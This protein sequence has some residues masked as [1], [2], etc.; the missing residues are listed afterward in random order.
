[1]GC[2]YS[3]IPLNHIEE[4]Y[5]IPFEKRLQ[6]QDQDCKVL[7]EMFEK[8]S[9][10]GLISSNQVRSVFS[11]CELP[12]D[13]HKEFYDFFIEAS[14]DNNTK[15][16]AILLEMTALIFSGIGTQKKISLLF[17]LYA[18]N[19]QNLMSKEVLLQMLDNIL[20]VAIDA[21][22]VYMMNKHFGNEDI[23]KYIRNISDNRSEL[24]REYFDKI[25]ENQDLID[26]DRFKANISQLYFNEIFTPSRIRDHASKCYS[27]DDDSEEND[28]RQQSRFNFEN[29]K[30]S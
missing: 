26:L 27:S 18:K 13:E 17:N 3:K 10:N 5:F 21:I 20:T 12:F 19:S 25:T 15:Y 28:E 24:L 9:N 2:Y 29:A 16:S 6:Y 4:D 14:F 8:S 22:C 30:V 7:I 11:Q 23:Q 1:M